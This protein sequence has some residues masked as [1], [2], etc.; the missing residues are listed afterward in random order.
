MGCTPSQ[1]T[2]L[3]LTLTL[4][5][6]LA[7]AYLCT[8][9]ASPSTLHVSL[10]PLQVAG[11]GLTH[12]TSPPYLLQC[13]ARNSVLKLVRDRRGHAE[14]RFYAS[15]P[16]VL[17]PHVPRCLGLLRCRRPRARAAVLDDVTFHAP[18][19]SPPPRSDDAYTTYLELEDLAVDLTSPC[20]LDVKVGQRTYDV[21]APAEKVAYEVS[22]YPRQAQ[23][24]FRISGMCVCGEMR[25]KRWG[26]SLALDDVD[27]ALGELFARRAGVVEEVE[28]QLV[29]LCQVFEVQTEYVFVASSV[30]IVF[31]AAAASR[32]PVVRLIDFGH[33]RACRDGRRDESTLYGLR[34][35]AEAVGRCRA[36]VSHA[37]V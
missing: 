21:D 33:A 9:R 2:A 8:H 19:T 3:T 4:T 36:R 10:H 22:K 15:L 16:H 13:R 12:P 34:R 23:V 14:V 37:R 20:V 5:F 25:D 11:H 6:T 29:D 27:V 30:L 18:A 31:D 32:P 7:T 1:P 17:A 26:Q 35:L 28:R 24:G